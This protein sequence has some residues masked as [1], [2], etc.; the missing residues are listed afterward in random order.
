MFHD[1]NDFWI[2]IPYSF[3]S[4]SKQLDNLVEDIFIL[5]ILH[6]CSFND[7]NEFIYE[8]VFIFAIL[9]KH[10]FFEDWDVDCKGDIIW[11]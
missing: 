6:I 9:N 1:I 8:F 10:V 3:S 11:A 7:L 5:N 2:I 4:T